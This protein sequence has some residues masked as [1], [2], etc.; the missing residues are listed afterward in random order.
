[1]TAL[2]VTRWAIIELNVGL[3]C[4][5]L[6]PTP[7]STNNLP[8]IGFVPRKGQYP[9]DEEALISCLHC[10]EVGVHIYLSKLRWSLVP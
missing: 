2:I 1:M 9:T 4:K 10:I 8:Y 7:R 6:P 5:V 3:G